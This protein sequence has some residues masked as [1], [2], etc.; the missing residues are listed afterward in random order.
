MILA[1]RAAYRC[2]LLKRYRAPLPVIVVGNITVGGTGKTPL[3]IRIVELLQQQGFKPAVISRGYGGKTTDWPHSVTATSDPGLV[4]DEPSLIV[5]RTGCPLVIDPIRSRATDHLATHTEC[6][7]IISDDGLQHYALERDIEIAVIDGQRRWGNGLMLPAGPL[8]EPLTRLN[9]VDLIVGNGSAETGEYVMHLIGND[10]VNLLDGQKVPLSQF[11]G[12]PLHAMA[13]IGNPERF[14]DHLK[15]FGLQFDQHSFPDHH[16]YSASELN[17]QPS[18]PLLMTE[19]DSVKC[20]RFAASH[21]WSVPVDAQLDAS[22]EQQLLA[23]L[24]RIQNG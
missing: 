14:F 18:A 6:D 4:G 9:Q 11:A 16:D 10:A 1:R 24:K 19:K 15:T 2:G 3:V 13:G 12:K 8:R 20:R 22:F 21:H 23:L 7:I 5:Q 17:F